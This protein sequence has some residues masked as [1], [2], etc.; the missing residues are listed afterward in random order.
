MEQRYNVDITEYMRY[1]EHTC[2]SNRLL[3]MGMF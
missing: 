1:V 3:Q 2:S